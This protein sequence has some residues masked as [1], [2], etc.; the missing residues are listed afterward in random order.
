MFVGSSALAPDRHECFRFTDPETGRPMNEDH[1]PRELSMRD[2]SRAGHELGRAVVRGLPRTV[3][4]RA[5]LGRR[6]RDEVAAYNRKPGPVYVGFVQP[7]DAMRYSDGHRMRRPRELD[8]ERFVLAAEQAAEAGLLSFRVGERT[9]TDLD[10]EV[11]PA[12]LDELV[13][14]LERPVVARDAGHA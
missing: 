3:T 1:D 2:V 11:V 12:D 8:A 7:Q 9:V 10:T 5:L 4:L 6:I 13:A 14:V